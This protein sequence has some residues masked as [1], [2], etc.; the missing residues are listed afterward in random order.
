MFR[1]FRI[2]SS[3]GMTIP[4]YQRAMEVGSKELWRWAPKSY[5]GVLQRAIG[6]SSKMVNH[7]AFARQKKPSVIRTS[8]RAYFEQLK[9]VYTSENL[10]MF[11]IFVNIV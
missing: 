8:A 3:G 6:K 7:F 1:I 5:G 10:K 11:V 2:F 4:T 9:R